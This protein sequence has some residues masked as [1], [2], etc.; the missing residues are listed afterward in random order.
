[1]NSSL[2][3]L[4]KNLSDSDFEHLSQEFC[5]KKLKLVKQKGVHPHEHI[6]R[7]KL[8]D[9]CEFFRS[10]KDECFSEKDYLK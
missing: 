8:P 4:V 9:R 1:M 5:G 6:D 10:L 7:E 2:D 3:A